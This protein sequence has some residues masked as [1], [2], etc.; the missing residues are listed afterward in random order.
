MKFVGVLRKLEIFNFVIV[1]SQFTNGLS[2]FT[3]LAMSFFPSYIPWERSIIIYQRS[4]II[5]LARHFQPQI[6]SYFPS[7]MV[8]E[9]S[10]VI[11]HAHQKG[12]FF[13]KKWKRISDVT[14]AYVSLA[15]IL[16]CT[17]V[18]PTSHNFN[19][20]FP[21][22]SHPVLPPSHPRFEGI[23]ILKDSLIFFP[24]ALCGSFLCFVR[25]GFRGI[26][27]HS[28]NIQD[29]LGKLFHD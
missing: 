4:I 23:L 5:Y 11:Y 27:T 21:P 13:N 14:L 15:A 12:K 24:K 28:D 3:W 8:H 29:F 1:R 22:P 10:I 20:S 26:F 9:W 18:D 7:D 16:K 6:S 17:L 25:L 2:Y 19:W